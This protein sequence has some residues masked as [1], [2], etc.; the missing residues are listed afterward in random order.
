MF[1][2]VRLYGGVL[3]LC[4]ISLPVSGVVI[5]EIRIDQPGP[6]RNEYFE[7]AGHPGESLDGLSYLV[8][9]D[10][11][12]GASGVVEAVVNLDGHEIA[13]DGFFLVAERS[14]SLGF[15]VDFNTR[16]NFENNDNV[17]HLLVSGFS[18]SSGDD[19][20][21]DDDGVLDRSPW[22]AQLDALALVASS[23][24][25]DRVYSTITIGPFGGAVPEHVGRVPD[26]NGIWQIGAGGL[27]ADTPGF[28]NAPPRSVEVIAPPV[29][30]LLPGFL[31]FLLT[32]ARQAQKSIR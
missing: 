19:L 14:F 23:G 4:L 5:N 29:W 27:G 13:A 15:P 9:G 25:G 6:D 3:L 11:R 16:L 10:S 26:H 20:D 18:G 2:F 31:V 30:M 17:T 22:G 8:I 24:G 21:V 7:L 32:G 1:L 28:A 12:H